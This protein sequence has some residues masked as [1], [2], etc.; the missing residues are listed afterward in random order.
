MF[1]DKEDLSF[2]RL[3]SFIINLYFYKEEWATDYSNL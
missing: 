1:T 2:E 3:F